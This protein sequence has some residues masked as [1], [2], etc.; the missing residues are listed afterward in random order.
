MA[1]RKS[2]VLSFVLVMMATLG[3]ITLT[4]TLLGRSRAGYSHGV[5]LTS[6]PAA[7]CTFLDP[8]SCTATHDPCPMHDVAHTEPDSVVGATSTAGRQ[9][10]G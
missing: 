3:G 1:R 10:S 9:G 6:S 2:S 5:P 8:L 7:E 4:P